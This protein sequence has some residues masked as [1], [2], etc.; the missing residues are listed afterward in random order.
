VS[1]CCLT[2]NEQFSAYIM[3]R[4]V[5]FDELMVVPALYWTNTLSWKLI[6]L[7]HW[8]NSPRVDMSAHS[9]TLSWFR[10]N[11]SLLFLL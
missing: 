3:A 8:S 10:S 2:P 5:T 1:D 4:Q 9:D 7:V 11:Q 6:V